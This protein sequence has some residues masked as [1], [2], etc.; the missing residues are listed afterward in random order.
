MARYYGRAFRSACKLPYCNILETQMRLS[1]Q[2]IN[3]LECNT[4]AFDSRALW[5]ELTF[6]LQFE[7]YKL[8]QAKW[9]CSSGPWPIAHTQQ[10]LTINTDLPCLTP[11]LPI[12]L[13]HLSLLY[14]AKMADLRR[15]WIFD[16]ERLPMWTYQTIHLIGSGG[17]MVGLECTEQPTQC[18]TTIVK[19]SLP[20]LSNKSNVF[21][22]WE[23]QS[24]HICMAD[25]TDLCI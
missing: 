1:I 25:T 22:L 19:M 18:M 9:W 13:L 24:L 12:L 10:R 11:N 3:S 4:K 23:W 17:F 2:N 14:V 16:G 15:R 8:H 5:R 20:R 7:A 6:S 21:E